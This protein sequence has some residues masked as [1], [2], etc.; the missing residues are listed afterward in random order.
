MGFLGVCT[1]SW[2]ESVPCQQELV[3]MLLP[4]QHNLLF[5]ADRVVCSHSWLV[6]FVEAASLSGTTEYG[7]Y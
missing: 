3:G 1:I 5:L 6:A 4:G 7:L 2:A